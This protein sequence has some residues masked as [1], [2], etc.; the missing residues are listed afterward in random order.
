MSMAYGGRGSVHPRPPASVIFDP[1][2]SLWEWLT[3]WIVLIGTVTLAP[4]ISKIIFF[5][6]FCAT[7]IWNCHQNPSFS[8]HT[9]FIYVQ[10]LYNAHFFYYDWLIGVFNY[11]KW[12]CYLSRGMNIIITTCMT[13]AQVTYMYL[14]FDFPWIAFSFSRHDIAE[15]LLKVA[16]NTINQIIFI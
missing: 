6:N 2:L 10:K 14:I 3:S 16:L 8:Y 13:R 11:E 7:C 5:P 1:K 15:I 12:L 9:V 4:Q